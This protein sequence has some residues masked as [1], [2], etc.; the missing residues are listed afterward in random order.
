MV[1][2]KKTGGRRGGSEGRRWNKGDWYEGVS[3][4]WTQ[5]SAELEG[6]GVGRGKDKDKRTGEKPPPKAHK[7]RTA[8]NTEQD[9]THNTA[10]TFSPTQITQ[11]INITE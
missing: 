5:S 2:R 6:E 1:R 8:Q 7:R 9:E 11:I 4:L 10:A 3:E